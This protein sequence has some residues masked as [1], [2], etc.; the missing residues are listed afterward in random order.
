MF[1]WPIFV[2][3]EFLQISAAAILTV[4]KKS[5]NKTEKRLTEDAWNF[6]NRRDNNILFP[7]PPKIEFLQQRGTIFREA[8]KIGGISHPTKSWEN[9]NWNFFGNPFWPHLGM[10]AL[11]VKAE[12]VWRTLLL[13]RVGLGPAEKN[14]LKVRLHKR[15]NAS[16]YDGLSSLARR[17]LKNLFCP[18]HIKTWTKVLK[19]TKTIFAPYKT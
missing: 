10:R 17:Y 4:F 15:L 2:G 9:V 1:L 7:R 14:S 12:N 18:G 8:T 5:K 16:S 11:S 6:Q 13:Y 19:T 3:L